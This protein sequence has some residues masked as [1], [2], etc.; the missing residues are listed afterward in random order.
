MSLIT[1]HIAA[2]GSILASGRSVIEPAL[3]DQMARFGVTHFAG[4]PQ[5]FAMMHRL[6]PHDRDLPS[7]RGLLQAGGRLSPTLIE[8][9]DNDCRTRGREFF[10][11]YGQTEAAPRMACLPPGRLRDKVGSVGQAIP[12]GHFQIRDA[13]DAPLASGEVGEVVYTGPNVMMGY[14]NRREDL[15]NGDEFGGVLHTGDLGYLDREGFL[16][17]VGRAKR[18]AK[19][20]GVRVSLDEVEMIAEQFLPTV[21]AVARGDDG[22]ALITTETDAGVLEQARRSVA[23]ELGAPFRLLSTHVVEHLPLLANGKIDYGSLSKKVSVDG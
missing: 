8:A 18:I 7:L 14:A 12:G 1:S 11:M 21:V 2:G 10:V 3:W 20:A 4:V 6:R 15:G 22:V 16:F 19:L 17:L 13:R 23:S 9:F 5:S